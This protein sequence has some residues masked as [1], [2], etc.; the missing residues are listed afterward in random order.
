ETRAIINSTNN[1]I[2]I[3]NCRLISD[4]PVSM[5]HCWGSPTI[6]V[7]NCELLNSKGDAL[8]WTY[9]SQGQLTVDNSVV[10]AASN[11]RFIFARNRNTGTGEELSIGIS[12]TTLL[13]GWGTLGL[14]VDST[15]P[16]LTGIGDASPT[17]LSI[18]FVANVLDVPGPRATVELFPHD[19]LMEAIKAL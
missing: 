13:M 11:G 18:Q 16:K 4:G 7:Q 6:T 5:L 2:A 9:D 14:T 3:A 19:K 8:S 17:P 15:G 1:R 12:R 10:A